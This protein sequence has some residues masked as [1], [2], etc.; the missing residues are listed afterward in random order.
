[1]PGTNQR[2]QDYREIKDRYRPTRTFNNV[3]LVR[4][5]CRAFDEVRSFLRV[6]AV[7]HE[8]GSAGSERLRHLRRA[9]TVIAILQAA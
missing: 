6:R 3:R 8:H 7:H 4:R 5:F 2:K 9:V 1:M